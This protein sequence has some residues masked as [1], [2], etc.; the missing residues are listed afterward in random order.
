MGEELTY[1]GLN[2]HLGEPVSIVPLHPAQALSESGWW[3]AQL[4]D[5]GTQ[6]R[7]AVFQ[8]F[9]WLARGE[10]A[11]AARAS[12]A[13]TAYDGFVPSAGSRLDPPGAGGAT[14]ATPPGR[15]APGA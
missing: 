12:D 14:S 11:E 8:A 4:R 6:G 5:V 15:L 2:V 1:G 10:A 9:P 7:D 3:L 13:F